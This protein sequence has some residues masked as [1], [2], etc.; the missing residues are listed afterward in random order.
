MLYQRG[1]MALSSERSASMQNLLEDEY[2]FAWD[3]MPGIVSVWAYRDGRAILWR[4]E[5]D[6]VLCLQ[7][8]YYPWLLATSLDDLAHLGPALQ[9]MV[10]AGLIGHGQ[11][12]SGRAG[13]GPARPLR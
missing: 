4:R 1:R 2:L 9:P 13:S 6:R 5:Q 3:L 8:R 10:G 7:E 11:V 12:G